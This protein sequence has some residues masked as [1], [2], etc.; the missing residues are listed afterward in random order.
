M[1]GGLWSERPPAPSTWLLRSRELTRLLAWQAPDTLVAHLP[2]TIH[3][4]GRVRP[5]KGARCERLSKYPYV[6]LEAC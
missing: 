1:T 5:T 4:Q 2:T 3:V 6:F